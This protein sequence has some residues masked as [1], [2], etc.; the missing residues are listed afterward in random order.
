MWRQTLKW[1]SD[2]SGDHCRHR[3]SCNRMLTSDTPNAPVQ[4]PEHP[5]G[6]AALLTRTP[7]DGMGGDW[8]GAGDRESPW[9]HCWLRLC[10]PERAACTVVLVLGPPALS[11]RGSA[12]AWEQ[13][14]PQGSC[15]FPLCFTTTGRS[16]C[17]TQPCLAVA[18][19]GT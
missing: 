19:G 14:L 1:G 17:L 11:G 15:H 10:W 8:A 18:Y 4:C 6:G 5:Q 9:G 3:C 2:R 7:E 13:C 16:Y 12:R